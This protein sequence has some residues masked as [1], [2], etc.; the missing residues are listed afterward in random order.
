[1]TKI[2]HPVKT[3]RNPFEKAQN[4]ST[5]LLENLTPLDYLNKKNR[6]KYSIDLGRPQFVSN[7]S[8]QNYFK[9]NQSREHSQQIC[10]KKEK[11]REHSHQQLRESSQYIIQEKN[12]GFLACNDSFQKK[13]ITIRRENSF[14][15][16]LESMVND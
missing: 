7:R 11:S 5:F 10:F 8:K 6:Q 13:H 14:S 16:Q 2:N 12:K 4:S 3:R 1:M 9:K 15:S